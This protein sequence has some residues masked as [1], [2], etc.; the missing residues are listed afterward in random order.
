M[1]TKV[2]VPGRF[3][4]PHRGHILM[5]SYLL[6]IFD[7]VIIGIGSCYEVGTA[8]YPLLAHFREKMIL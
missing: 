5:F 8:R 1:K 6:E 2:L 3:S 7:E 4:P